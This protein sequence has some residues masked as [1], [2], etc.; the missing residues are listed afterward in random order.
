[1]LFRSEDELVRA[2]E[3]HGFRLGP[4][5]R[6]LGVSRPALYDRIER[7]ERVRK[8]RDLSEPEIR[9]ALETHEGDST[10]AA[11]ELRVSPRGLTLRMR[12]LG[13]R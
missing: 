7:S 4:V 5:A 3:A 11:E 13:M 2:L 9:V 12:E 10:R 6:A 1:V 8:A